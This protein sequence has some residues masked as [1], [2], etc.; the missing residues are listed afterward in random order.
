[1]VPYGRFDIDDEDS[2]SAR[3]EARGKA[4]LVHIAVVRLPRLSNFTDFSALERMEG[5]GVRYAAAPKQLEGADL[6]LL[7]GTKSTLA[8]LKWL[9][10]SGMEAQSSQTARGGR[11]GVRRVRRRIEMT[12]RTVSDPENT[13]GGGAM[14]GLGLLPV[15]TVFRPVKT[16]AQ[17]RGAVG[18]VCPARCAELV[19]RGRVAGYEIHMGETARDADAL[20]LI[21]TLTRAD[22]TAVWDGCQARSALRHLPARRVRRARTRRRRLAQAL[23]ARRGD[24]R[25]R[26]R[27]CDYGGVQGTRQYDLL[28]GY[29]AAGAGYGV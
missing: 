17:A 27:H 16:T 15:E 6:I 7:P 1:M 20:P 11:A 22:G 28:G 21:S 26:T 23:A 8:D 14:R 12:G 13:E 2:L 10:E 18:T 19:G 9:R 24:D 5:V 4:A 29:R 3:L 25:W